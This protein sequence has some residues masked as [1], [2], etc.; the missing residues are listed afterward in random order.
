VVDEAGSES[1]EKYWR[2]GFRRGWEA[3][4]HE[5]AGPGVWGRRPAQSSKRTVWLR[6]SRKAAG[7][8]IGIS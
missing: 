8:K 4:S 2:Q 7:G 5:P 1:L 6:I 3:G